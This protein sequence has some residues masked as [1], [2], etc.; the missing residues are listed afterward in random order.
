MKINISISSFSKQKWVDSVDIYLRLW[1]EWIKMSID[2]SSTLDFPGIHD[3]V[4]NEV[5]V[6]PLKFGNG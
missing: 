1:I 5:T 2:R 3:K 6:Q 4:W